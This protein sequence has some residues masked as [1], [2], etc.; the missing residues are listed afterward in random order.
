[1]PQSTAPRTDD[2]AAEPR[3]CPE[4]EEYRCPR[5]RTCW[6]SHELLTM[7]PP[8]WLCPDGKALMW[9]VAHN[10]ETV[11]N[12]SPSAREPCWTSPNR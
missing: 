9:T 7:R 6:C 12:N 2:A 1:M 3:C 4:G 11:D 5:C 8:R 10:G